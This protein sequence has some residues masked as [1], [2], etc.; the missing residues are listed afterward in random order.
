[1]LVGHGVF[2]MISPG[3]LAIAL[4]GFPRP[5]TSPHA[6]TSGDLLQGFW[7][8]WKWVFVN[9][10]ILI[11][12]VQLFPWTLVVRDGQAA[13]AD[14]QAVLNIGNL[15]NPIAFG[16]SNIVMPAVA[17][18]HASGTIRQAWRAAWTYIVIG[19]ALLS[20]FAVPVMLM[21]ETVLALFY[22]ANSPF[23]HLNQAVGLM[24]LA[25]AINS[26]ADM[27]SQFIFAVG[28][29]KVALWMNGISL[30]VVALLLP[31]V[32]ADGIAACALVLGTA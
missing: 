21:P 17:Q 22:G 31:F 18:A 28:S 2:G 9:G 29:G 7:T 30:G 15:A 6:I 25:V 26:I 14:L 5:Q 20:F 13:A 16:L 27:M 23:V 1:M 19:A 8:H 32:G 4:E 12:R 24:V 10:V 3:V 11:V